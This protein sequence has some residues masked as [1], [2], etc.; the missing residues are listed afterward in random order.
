MLILL[1]FGFVVEKHLGPRRYALVL[2]VG[3]AAGNIASALFYQ[4]KLFTGAQ[5]ATAALLGA[6]I[7]YRRT[8]REDQGTELDNR[9]KQLVWIILITLSIFFLDK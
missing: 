6:S 3:G 8:Y 9:W 5:S 7:A 2:F 4:Q 1:C